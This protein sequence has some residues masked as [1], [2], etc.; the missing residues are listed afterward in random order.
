MDSN[1]NYLA[2]KM[3]VQAVLAHVVEYSTEK[4]ITKSTA[5][6]FDEYFVKTRRS[7]R[8]RSK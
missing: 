5:K 3:Q 8:G 7:R 6:T 1:K 4:V 2:D